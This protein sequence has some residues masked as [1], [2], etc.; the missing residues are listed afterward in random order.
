MNA[1]VS[2]FSALD[3]IKEAWNNV[4]GSKGTFWIIL[5]SM[6][7]LNA[8]STMIEDY[9]S[10]ASIMTVRFFV[11]ELAYVVFT[12]TYYILFWGLLYL[13]IQRA[14]DQSIHYKMVSNVFNVRLFFR[15]IGILLFQILILLPAIILLFVPVLFKY[16]HFAVDFPGATKLVTALFYIFGLSLCLV[17]IYLLMRLYVA[18]AI[19]IAEK[20]E[21]VTAIKRSFQATKS[22]VWKLIGLSLLN[23][24]ILLLGIVTLGIGFIWLLPYYFIN[25]GVVYKKLTTY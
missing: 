19:L 5:F 1:I 17:A 14:R 25:Y 22:Q 12:I 7:F 16:T 18:K 15:M 21:L 13:G 8:V 20:T 24:L 3:T 23:S 4:K 10:I 2:N 11:G 6:L 9:A